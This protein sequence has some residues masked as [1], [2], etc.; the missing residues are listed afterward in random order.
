MFAILKPQEVNTNNPNQTVV[1]PYI[2]KDE[3]EIRDLI[4]LA[5]QIDISDLFSLVEY[6]WRKNYILFSYFQD[7]FE[8]LHYLLLTGPPGWGKGAILVTFKLLG[9][10]TIL[11]GDMSGA[12]RLENAVNFR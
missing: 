3:H 5:C 7:L 2:Y 4:K 11:A 8:A 1:M 10:R 9:Y 12:N 6:V